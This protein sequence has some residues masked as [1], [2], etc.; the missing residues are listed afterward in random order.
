MTGGRAPKRKGDIFERAVVAYLRE[1]GFPDAARAYGAG[2]PD[3][4]GD[5]AEVPGFVIECKAHRTLDLAAFMDQATRE[6]GARSV[7]PVVV[8]K[9]RGQDT[10]SAYVVLRLSDFARIA[11]DGTGALDA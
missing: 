9:R 1:H 2:R 8:A 11:L 6:A 4:V 10:G 5:I 3:G 7:I